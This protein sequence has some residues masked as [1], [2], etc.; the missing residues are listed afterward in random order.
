MKFSLRSSFTMLTV[1]GLLLSV[2]LAHGQDVQAGRRAFAVCAGC[3]SID[4]SNNPAGPTLKGVIGRPA[5]K[6]EFAGYSQALRQSG[7]T[8]TAEE[9]DAYLAAPTK[10]IPGTTM[11]INVPSEAQRRDLIA[12]L[13][14][15]R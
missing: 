9:L 11:F 10:K 7:I 8:W 5:G 1:S 6:G 2:S 14:S 12:Y 15:L 3:H 4:G 13:T